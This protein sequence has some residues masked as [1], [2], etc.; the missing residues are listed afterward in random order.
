MMGAWGG[1]N[2]A[3]WGGGIVAACGGGIIPVGGGG[4]SGG[5]G[6]RG[7][8]SKRARLASGAAASPVGTMGGGACNMPPDAGG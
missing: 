2:I 1:G 7:V 3:V 8:S 6:I 5:G 4:N